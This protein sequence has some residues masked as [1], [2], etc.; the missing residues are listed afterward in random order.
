[1]TTTPL[2]FLPAEISSR[3]FRVA[4]QPCQDC[5]RPFGVALEDLAR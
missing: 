2:P 4:P 5:G 3:K 1:M